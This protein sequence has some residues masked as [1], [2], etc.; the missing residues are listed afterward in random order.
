MKSG[1]HLR[2]ARPTDNLATLAAMYA[3][4]LGLTLLASF[5]DH[6]GFD[7]VMLGHPDQPWHLEF[8]SQRGH[9]AGRAPTED[10]LLVFYLPERDEWEQCC[11]KMLSAGFRAVPSA[12]PYWD[13]RGKTFED[14]DGYRVVLQNAAWTTTGL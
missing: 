10:N 9:A 1:R 2:I 12:N 5:S 4:G 13:Q 8:T 3:Q 7:G 11:Q 6:D 14:L